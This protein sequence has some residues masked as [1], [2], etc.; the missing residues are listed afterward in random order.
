MKIVQATKLEN[1]DWVFL[2]ERRTLN[3]PLVLVF[4]NRYLLEDEKVI[5]D[6]REKFPF[7]H[8]VFGSTS[9]EISGCDVND[10]SISVTAIEFEKNTFIV[11]SDNVLNYDKKAKL[12]GQALYDA[13]PKENLKHLFVWLALLPVQLTDFSY[14]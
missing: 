9:G 13:M 3:N 11:K 14:F 6:I 8:L 12:L 2:Q 5:A 4:A 1:Q 10:N 7:E